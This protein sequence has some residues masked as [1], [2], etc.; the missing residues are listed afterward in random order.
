MSLQNKTI[1]VTGGS[2]FIGKNIAEYF[3]KRATVL[4]PPHKSLDLQSQTDIHQF[5]EDHDIDY[6]I[7]C[8]NIG[9]VRG[10]TDP[11]NVVEHN[12]RMFFNLAENGRYF[13]RL[14]HFG[15][16][17]EYDK[18]QALVN[19]NEYEF[20][21]SIPVDSYGFSKY[22]ISKYIEKS[23]NNVCLRLFGIFGKYE[24][25]TRFITYAIR[26]NLQE[27]PIIINQNVK[28]DYLYVNDLM[29]IIPFFFTDD[30]KYKVYNITTG[31]SRDLVSIANL[32]NTVS[33]YKS[34]IKVARKG[35]G[36]E[37]SGNNARLLELTNGFEF[38]QIKTAISELMEYYRRTF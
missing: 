30:Y 11:P 33:D 6:V 29:R 16:G 22:V 36:N 3:S 13:E 4:V 21:K 12:I 26:Q 8:A 38:T 31:I 23:G 27:L 35:L 28:F 32:I 14:V 9:G 1:L 7:H 10:V 25:D 15:S 18:R 19:V 34:E 24:R 17:A 20:G 5:F 2:G 37:Y